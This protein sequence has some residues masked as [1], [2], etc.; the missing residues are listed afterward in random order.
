MT[1]R[2]RDLDGDYPIK[3]LGV[4]KLAKIVGAIFRIEPLRR[5]VAN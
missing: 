1:S 4:T 3:P 5:R 2:I